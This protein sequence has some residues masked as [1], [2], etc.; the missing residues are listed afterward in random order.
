MVH[1]NTL[2]GIVGTF[3]SHYAVY[4]FKDYLMEFLLM[5]ISK[6]LLLKELVY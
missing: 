6:A 2:M 1:E 3:N 4:P 5:S